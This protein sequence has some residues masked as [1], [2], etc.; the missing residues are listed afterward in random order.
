MTW[1][2]CWDANLVRDQQFIRQDVAEVDRNLLDAL[3]VEPALRQSPLRRPGE[4][5]DFTPATQADLLS[6]ITSEGDHRTNRFIAVTGIPGT[7]KSHL[8]HWVYRKIEREKPDWLEVRYVP[9][10]CTNLR[11]IVRTILGSTDDGE[12][13]LLHDQ[14]GLM[15]VADDLTEDEATH[16][17]WAELEHVLRFPKENLEIDAHFSDDA[18]RHALDLIETP[19]RGLAAFVNDENVRQALE[20]GDGLLRRCV[21]GLADQHA[22]DS[23]GADVTISED[24]LHQLLQLAPGA[25]W[26]DNLEAH[27]ETTVGVLNHAL[28]VARGR[29]ARLVSGDLSAALRTLREILC[30]RDKELLIVFEDFSDARGIQGTLFREFEVAPL[31]DNRLVRCPVRF[32]IAITNEPFRGLRDS[33]M[34]R[35]T[36]WRESSEFNLDHESA[37]SENRIRELFGRYMNVA[38][39]GPN[40]VAAV[41][42]KVP[43]KCTECEL[44]PECHEAFG[45][46]AGFGLFPLNPSSIRGLAAA[47]SQNGIFNP[48]DFL[49]KTTVLPTLV[50]APEQLAEAKFPSGSAESFPSMQLRDDLRTLNSAQQDLLDA[51]GVAGEELA[52]LDHIVR[53]WEPTGRSGSLMSAALGFP[54]DLVVGAEDPNTTPKPKPKTKPSPTAAPTPTPAQEDQ[55]LARIE[56]WADPRAEVLLPAPMRA[57]IQK[58]VWNILKSLAVWPEI[59]NEHNLVWNG[60]PV[61]KYCV[62]VGISAGP[63]IHSRAIGFSPQ[64]SPIITFKR[65]PRSRDTLIAIVRMDPARQAANHLPSEV[66]AA[67]LEKIESFKLEL[68]DRV[69][70]L[71]RQ[72][73][74]NSWAVRAPQLQTS[75]WFMNAALEPVDTNDVPIDLGDA[76]TPA[77]HAADEWRKLVVQQQQVHSEA[78]LQVAR[79][80]GR[81]QGNGATQVWDL[82]NRE[83]PIDSG[84]PTLDDFDTAI[85]AQ[86][87]LVRDLHT[88]IESILGESSLADTHQAA[89]RLATAMQEAN[90]NV[91]PMVTNLIE[92]T[93]NEDRQRVVTALRDSISGFDDLPLGEKILRLRRLDLDLTEAQSLR[94]ALDQANTRLLDT[95]N[96][97][98]NA[99]EGADAL[100]ALTKLAIDNAREAVREAMIGI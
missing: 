93:G 4:P 36:T 71:A 15:T 17:L 89:Q 80:F 95:Q 23:I 90:G 77:A 58:L 50:N 62:S 99:D 52:R 65:D 92:E 39:V 25:P 83:L 74:E 61:E 82:E 12:I 28:D 79:F 55:R 63:N 88:S 14:V 29:T 64:E 27:P 66:V 57:S 37:Y 22:A 11:E 35:A 81:S 72:E 75:W 6:H 100:A 98:G 54:E 46:E 97:A 53:W 70:V 84:D 68:D 24:D 7:G 47:A 19:K 1:Q 31:E 44:R 32:V 48:R 87:T 40:A 30:R 45:S 86:S 69:R 16:K 73:R 5:Q 21:R 49:L 60:D 41:R 91:N 3:H 85:V 8:L 20:S 34:S 67:D 78:A 9:K 33:F 51:S 76:N 13:R 42:P 94:Y 18:R 56:R 10:S 26:R 2:A 96:L 59:I 38:R 43:N